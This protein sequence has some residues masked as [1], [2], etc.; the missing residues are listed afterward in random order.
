L[1]W[2]RNPRGHF[3]DRKSALVSGKKL[4]KTLVAFANADGGEALVGVADDDDEPIPEKRWN[5]FKSL[6]DANGL[7]QSAFNLQPTL[8]LRYEILESDSRG[9][10]LRIIVEKSSQVCKTS[11][12]TVYVRHGAQSLP[13][14]N[15]EKILELSFAK[16]TTSFEDQI[17]TNVQAEAVVESPKVADFLA[18]Y[19]PKTDPLD[20]VANQNL[21]DPQSWRPRVAGVLLFAQ[22]PAAL[23]PTKC[24]AK[25]V[26]YETKE[27]DPE[28]DHLKTI[29][30]IEGSLYDVIHKTVA[31][32]TETMSSVAVWTAK[33]LGTA[34]YPPE[35]IWE[36]IVNA[37]IHRDYS[38]SDDVQ[39]KIFDNRIEVLSPGRLPGYVKVDNILDSRYSRNPKIVRTLNWYKNP[40]NKD[41]G[42][43]LN[44]AFQKM[45]DWG[46]R[47]P[48]ISEQGN[49]V[50]VV[51]PHT[52]L[53]SPSEAYIERVP[54]LEGPKSAWRRTR[55]KK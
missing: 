43:G 54:G 32:V 3:F 20:Y 46:L 8:D 31:A 11:D 48:D 30:S 9:Y 44:T 5:G 27:D 49:Y 25:V 10:V 41:L 13:V 14:E 42:E 19:S 16:G 33:G 4:Q 18:D 45:K 50:S 26:R 47:E 29:I 40:P 52:P 38:I 7:L 35:A 51:L 53:A 22:N 6:E 39:V 36:I 2:L 28:R 34:S 37:F 21:L 1:R 24:S 17:L 12:G 15:P 23:M 55:K